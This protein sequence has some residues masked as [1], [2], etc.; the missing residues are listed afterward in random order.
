MFAYLTSEIN[1]SKIPADKLK[2]IGLALQSNMPTS[3]DI[4]RKY[5]EY[6]ETLVG[7]H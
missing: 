5:K 7:K 6:A 1:K 4:F 2:D 3:L